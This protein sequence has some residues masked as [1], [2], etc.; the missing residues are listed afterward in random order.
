LGNDSFASSLCNLTPRYSSSNPYKNEKAKFPSTYC[1][2]SVEKFEFQN[3]I[4]LLPRL[5][6]GDNPFLDE[7]HSESAYLPA[8]LE[9]PRPTLNP[10]AEGIMPFPQS[11]MLG[12]RVILFDT[13]AKLPPD[14]PASGNLVDYCA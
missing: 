8:I 3:P 1:Q 7:N 2:E 6:L 10:L 5:T 14:F 9:I 12:V 11:S 4:I 13:S